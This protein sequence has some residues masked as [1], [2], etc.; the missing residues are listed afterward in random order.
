MCATAPGICRVPW[1]GFFYT[2]AKGG[3]Q[4]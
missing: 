2:H 4:M 3:N 1:S